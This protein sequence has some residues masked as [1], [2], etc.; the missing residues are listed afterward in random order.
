MTGTVQTTREEHETCL[1]RF[2]N[3]NMP[4]L[5]RGRPRHIPHHERR[6]Q[7]LRNASDSDRDADLTW[8]V[9]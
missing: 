7:E 4:T 3:F 5:Y 2:F 8:V 6:Q 9:L 1:L